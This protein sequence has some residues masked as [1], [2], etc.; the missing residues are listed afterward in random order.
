[1]ILSI[2]KQTEEVEQHKVPIYWSEEEQDYE[3]HR[4]PVYYT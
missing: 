2:Q 4:T 3:N 1:M